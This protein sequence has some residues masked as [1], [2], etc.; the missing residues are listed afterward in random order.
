MPSQ[1]NYISD[2]QKRLLHP[3]PTYST[4]YRRGV[5]PAHKLHDTCQFTSAARKRANNNRDGLWPG[6]KNVG[7]SRIAVVVVVSS[8]HATD[9]F[10]QVCTDR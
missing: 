4:I 8:Q 5:Q 10:A 1:R 3:I 7:R 2:V 6:K 9:G